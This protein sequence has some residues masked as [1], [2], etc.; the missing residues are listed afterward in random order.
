[1]ANVY[2]NVDLSQLPPPAVVEELDYEQILA[3]MLADLQA[4]D[5]SFSALV[6]SDPA[7]KILE[8]AA[9]REML[10]RQRVNDAAKAVMIAFAQ[11]ADLDHLGANYDVRRLVITPAD[12]DA[13]PPVEAVYESDDD[14]RNRIVLSLEGYTTAGS[15]GS[16]QFHAL[17]ASG[18]VKDVAVDSDT[19]GTVQVAVL[20]RTGTGVA[21]EETLEAVEESLTGEVRRPL[22][23]TVVVQSATIVPYAITAS[24]TLFPGV[25]QAEVLAAAQAAAEAYA[26]EQHRLGRD[27]TRSGLFAALHQEGVQNVDLAAPASDIVIAWDE[28]PNCVG[29]SLEIEGTDE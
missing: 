2:V 16:Y 11:G 18:D 10:V 24:L 13:I 12:P 19:P 1:M 27:I 3:A 29:I 8:V 15:R 28:A 7:Y 26:A 23:D 22:C 14:F 25:G 4:R 9:Y 21:P 6:E 20:S 17:S 5:P